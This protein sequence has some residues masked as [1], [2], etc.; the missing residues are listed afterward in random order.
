MQADLQEKVTF[1][2]TGKLSGKSLQAID[3]MG[4]R[5]ALFAGYRDLTR[6]RYDFPLL[7][8]QD[9]ASERFAL[10]L[11]ALMDTL[12]ERVATSKDADRIRQ[13]VL[14]LE[15]DLRTLVSSGVNASL[16][17]LWEMA[18]RPLADSDKRFAES[19][20]LARANLSIDGALVDCDEALPYR[21]LS[22]AWALTQT[23]KARHLDGQIAALVLKL[24]NILKADFVN[25][26]AGKSAEQLR[27]S[28]GSGP[29]DSF[30]F[31]VMSRMLRRSSGRQ[32]LSKSRRRRVQHLLA[33]LQ[34]QQFFPSSAGGAGAPYS[35]AFDSCGAAL[36]AYRERLPKAIHLAKALAIAELEVNG[37]YRE[38]I[39]DTLFE[40][41]GEGGLEARDL[42]RFP[43]YLVRIGD[44]R[45]SAAE[46][47]RLTE[48]LSADLPIKIVLQI[49]DVIDPSPVGN[50]H[51]AF[52]MG[53]RRLTHM[54]LGMNDVF[55]LQSPSSNL[56]RMSKA[57]QAGLDY[58]GPALFSVFSGVSGK[59]GGY[60]AYLIAAA[61][62]ESRVFPAFVFDPS[63]GSS[64]AERFSLADNPQS[65]LDWPRQSFR[66]EDAQSQT[67]IEKLPFTSIDFVASDPRHARHFAS[68]A[69]EKW[70]GSLAGPEE[71]LARQDDGR[72]DRVPSLLMVDASN[73]LQR[74]IVDEKLIRAA[75]RCQS[76]WHSLQEL[77]GINNSH[78]RRELETERAAFDERLKQQTGAPTAVQPVALEALEAITPATSGAAP[79]LPEPEAQRSPD[80]AYIETAR[81]ST[82]NECT[83][84]NNKMFAYD[85]NQQAYIADVNAGTYAQLVEAAESCQ[86]AI[87]HP[88]KPRDP[89]EPGL[90]DL[91]KRAEPFL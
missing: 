81:C 46:Q 78:V 66:Y 52:A 27:A 83:Q 74:V 75:R 57:I 7:L 13:H 8:I 87:I 86:V 38:A 41:F 69:R 58:R 80:E 40:S 26:D 76:L 65:A 39:H 43:D 90:D 5:P 36:K 67:V 24:E 10:P 50:G 79:E 55:V 45:M 44:H 37:E 59:A 15:E 64:W 88:G 3:G 82:C 61:A 71:I 54:A 89:D 35:F 68:I 49:D 33:A 23:R 47:G 72:T 85:S 73:G 21:L 22:H 20:S 77:G 31:E 19:L 11:S 16:F 63:A 91:I 32:R 62:M 25:S 17:E 60:P 1:Y 4:L 70:N 84:I 6:L 18:A 29:M 14:R 12:L 30:D 53:S 2:L 56:P 34:S 48:I 28:F 51:L 42:A 9:D